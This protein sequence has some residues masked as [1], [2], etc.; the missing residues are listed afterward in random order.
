MGVCLQ[1]TL[2][3]KKSV[4]Q[5]R[6]MNLKLMQLKSDFVLHRDE[7]DD[8]DF[9]ARNPSTLLLIARA[10]RAAP[11]GPRRAEGQSFVP[12]AIVY[13]NPGREYARV[14]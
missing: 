10:A 13:N 5:N 2:K 7:D 11:R 14:S 6:A 1:R 3:K 8:D 12:G 4:T 9:I